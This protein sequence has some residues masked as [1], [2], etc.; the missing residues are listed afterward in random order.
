MFTFFC[1]FVIK[2]FQ[3]LQ[4]HRDLGRWTNQASHG[5]DDNGDHFLRAK[6][7]FLSYA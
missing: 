5:I 4:L 2:Y 6:G 3:V 7:Y 1:E